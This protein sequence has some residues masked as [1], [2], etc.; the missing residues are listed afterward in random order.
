M[1]LLLDDGLISVEVLGAGETLPAGD[2]IFVAT[3]S[4]GCSSETAF[5]IGE[6]NELVIDVTIVSEDSGAGDGQAEATV[7]G[8]TPDY[9]VV[10]NNM[11]GMEANPD[12]LSGGLYT[13]VVTDANGCTATASLT[14]TVDGIVEFTA[15]EGALFPVPV[16]DALNVRLATPL[17]STARVDIRDVQGRLIESTQ[18]L[19]NQQLLVLDAASWNAGVYTIQI[20]NEEARASW[21]FVK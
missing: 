11:A 7:T 6:P 15:L 16:T 21:S 19:P 17:N 2:Y 20:S 1:W 18:M 5:T 3:D 10:W 4:L 12:S 9:N 14:M 13:A 8:G